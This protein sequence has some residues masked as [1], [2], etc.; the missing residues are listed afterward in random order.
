MKTFAGALSKWKTPFNQ[1]LEAIPMGILITETYDKDYY[2][3]EISRRVLSKAVV[4][5]VTNK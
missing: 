1:F 2:N 4:S 3:N 5:K